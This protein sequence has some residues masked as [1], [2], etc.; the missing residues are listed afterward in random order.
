MAVLK[1]R[2]LATRALCS[3]RVSL[4]APVWRTEAR[5]CGSARD[6]ASRR[7]QGL[8]RENVSHELRMGWVQCGKIIARLTLHS[9]TYPWFWTANL[10]IL[11]LVMLLQSVPN[12]RI[13]V[14]PGDSSCRKFRFQCLP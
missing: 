5:P 6:Q 8:T 4:C 9:V 3:N 12:I 2:P 1:A 10:S 14:K 13:V 11:L 7:G